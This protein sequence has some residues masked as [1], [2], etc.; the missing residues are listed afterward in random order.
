MQR[1]N[2]KIQQRLNSITYLEQ[3]EIE[4]KLIQNSS[5]ANPYKE[6]ERQQFRPKNKRTGKFLVNPEIEDYYNEINER[7]GLGKIFERVR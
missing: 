7:T 6:T 5:F 1:E 2:E 4:D 3:K